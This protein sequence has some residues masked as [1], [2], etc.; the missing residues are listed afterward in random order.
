MAKLCVSR[1]KWGP[2]SKGWYH[3]GLNISVRDPPRWSLSSAG[4]G[5]NHPGCLRK[6]AMGK[7]AKGRE[8]GRAGG[9]RKR[10]AHQ[11]GGVGAR[12]QSSHASKQSLRMQESD[13]WERL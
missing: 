2:T 6:Q 1:A 10:Q 12:Q 13:P 5:Y 8:G 11:W 7:K 9:T 3:T 4:S